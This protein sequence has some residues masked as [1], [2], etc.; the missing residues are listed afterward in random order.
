MTTVHIQVMLYFK[1]D[2]IKTLQAA[3][4]VMIHLQMNIIK[5]L[6]AFVHTFFFVKPR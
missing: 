4:T 1:H 5:H 2:L 3:P 6:I